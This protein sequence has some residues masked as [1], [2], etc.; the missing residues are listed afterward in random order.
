M[1]KVEE[2]ENL[3]IYCEFATPI[4]DTDACVCKI[5]GIVNADS[6]CRKFK[7]DLLKIKPRKLKAFESSDKEIFRF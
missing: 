1:R 4:M 7:L 5:R 6:Y 2:E 3:C